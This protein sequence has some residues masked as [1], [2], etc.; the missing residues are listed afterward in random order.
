[1]FSQSN[2]STRHAVHIIRNPVSGI[3]DCTFIELG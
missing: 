1:M 3:T 2:Y